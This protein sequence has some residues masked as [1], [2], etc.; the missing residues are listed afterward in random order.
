[1][2]AS[3]CGVDAIV[4][5][6]AIVGDPACARDP[7]YARE[8]NLV[9]SINLLQECRAR[10]V[11]RFI[12][13]STCSNYGSASTTDQFADERTELRPLSVYA[14]TKVEF[15]KDMF[16][17]QYGSHLS[18]TSLRLATLYGVSPR[19]RFDL[20]VNEFTL[21]VLTRKHLV[22][23]GENAWRPY[24]H[25]RDAARA[26]CEVLQARSANAVEV[27]N[28]GSTSQ[29]FRKRDLVDFI[30][31][32]APAAQIEYVAKNEQDLRN[33]R[34]S[35]DKIAAKLSFRTN[36]TVQDG[37]EEVARLVKS[38]VINAGAYPRC[39]N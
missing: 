11:G 38:N 3:L 2:R 35:F 14:E 16:D 1:M 31:M 34:V 26:I 10:A 5:L 24:V 12:F 9:A 15:E 8:V 28:V 20:T 37:I 17:L 6:A 27:Y 13:A 23:H 22:V 21:E 33:Y 25:V 29:N 7:A 4:H 36:W 32:H 18:V 19:M 39:R 30:R